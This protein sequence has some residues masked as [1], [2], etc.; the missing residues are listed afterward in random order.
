ME[1]KIFSCLLFRP[2]NCRIFGLLLLFL[3]SSIWSEGPGIPSRSFSEA[4]LFK[5][6]GKIHNPGEPALHGMAALVNGYLITPIAGKNGGMWV[7]TIQENLS[8]KQVF[9]KPHLLN[10]SHTINLAT[11]GDGKIY[12]A[13]SSKEGVDIWNVTDPTNPT[14]V[15]V[16]ELPGIGPTKNEAAIWW[17][18]WQGGFL[19]ASTPGKGV[20][21]VDTKNINSP[22]LL[23]QIPDSRLGNYSVAQNW[24]FGNSM[25]CAV[26]KEGNGFSTLDIGTPDSPA[27]PQI[28]F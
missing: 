1:F 11:R 27:S 25:V 9:W 10:E 20:Y 4:Q 15:T 21:V 26:R 28:P 23:A 8:L 14:F 18:S 12:M 7:N 17:I 6:T 24:A 19:Y 22:K 5:H 16:I 13:L 3:A 2:R